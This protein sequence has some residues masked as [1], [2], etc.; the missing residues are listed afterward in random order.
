MG[1]DVRFL[2]GLG[3]RV[4][5]SFLD[6]EVECLISLWRSEESEE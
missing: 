5:G 1:W 4:R 2:C 6:D 3:R